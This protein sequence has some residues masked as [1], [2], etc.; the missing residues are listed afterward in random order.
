MVDSSVVGASVVD[1]SVVGDSVM[2]DSTTI[3]CHELKNS[4]HM[5]SLVSLAT[6][7]LHWGVGKA[8]KMV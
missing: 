4:N 1:S 6:L 7:S 8:R 5:N 3:K 2:G